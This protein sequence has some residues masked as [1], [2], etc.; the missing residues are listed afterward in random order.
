[1]SAKGQ[2]GEEVGGKVT[3]IRVFRKLF[4][5][6]VVAFSL[7]FKQVMSKG[8]DPYGERGLLQRE[9]KGE[10]QRGHRI[11]LLDDGEQFRLTA[12]G[13]TQAP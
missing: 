5:L 12:E 11:V 10:T 13:H 6:E 9:P 7:S 1:M 8:A 2:A 3:G 4:V